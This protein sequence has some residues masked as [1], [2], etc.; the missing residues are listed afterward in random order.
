MPFYFYCFFSYSYV[1]LNLTTIVSF[2]FYKKVFKFLTKKLKLTWEMPF[3][4]A[5]RTKY[6]CCFSS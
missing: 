6:E 2:T 3:E 5:R 1:I 4:E